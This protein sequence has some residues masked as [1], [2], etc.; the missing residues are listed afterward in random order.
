MERTVEHFKME[1][2]YKRSLG[3]VVGAFLTGLR[4]GRIVG[5]RTPQGK[6]LCPPLE[7][8]PQTGQAAT[9]LVDLADTGEVQTWSWV[10]EPLR[11]HPLDHPFAFA[12]I[13]I[14]GAD[15]NL[16]HAVDVSDPDQLRVG[17]RVKARFAAERK[18]H[19][20]DLECFVPIS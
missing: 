16:I 3:P 2:P 11:K 12:A 7:Y 8:D 19:I 14:D 5:V 9:D 10:P 13:R 4:D 6:V 15:T 18:G 20:R 17:L 1:L